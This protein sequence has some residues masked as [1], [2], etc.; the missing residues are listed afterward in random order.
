MTI[1]ARDDAAPR[2]GQEVQAEGHRLPR[3]AEQGRGRRRRDLPRRP[4][5]QLVG[6]GVGADQGARPAG[7]S[8]RLTAL[9]GI[10]I[11]RRHAPDLGETLEDDRPDEVLEVGRVATTVRDREPEQ[12]DSRAPGRATTMLSGHL[13][14]PLRRQQWA[15][16]R[17]RC[18]RGR[19]RPRS[20]G[21]APRGH[22]RPAGRTTRATTGEPARCA[23]TADPASPSVHAVRCLDDH[24]SGQAG[25][26]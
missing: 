7:A 2:H 19:A 1:E 10:E 25:D 3:R 4:S 24:A 22:R 9:A 18:R 6:A 11:V 5:H 15:L 12:H 14:G 21:R 20:G 26:H 23:A 17:P 13:V 8:D 16:P